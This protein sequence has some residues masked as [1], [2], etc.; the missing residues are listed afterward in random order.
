MKISGGDRTLRMA[1]A[2]EVPAMFVAEHVYSPS[3]FTSILSN[4]NIK[5]NYFVE[6][7]T[8]FATSNVCRIPRTTAHSTKDNHTAVKDGEL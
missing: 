6:S 7:I 2:L 4:L 8:S 3:S 1:L 5:K